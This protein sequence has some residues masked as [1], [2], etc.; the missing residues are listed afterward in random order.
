MEP[1]PVSRDPRLQNRNSRP[2]LPNRLSH[3]EAQQQASTVAQQPSAPNNQNDAPGD[4]FIRGI[5]DLVHRAVSA[6][7]N[8]NEKAKIKK[9][10]DET[11]DML[12]K[13]KSHSS[14]PSTVEF[15]QQNQEQE[16][17]AL[18][19]RD[20]DIKKY[21][22]E[23]Q[24]LVDDLKNKWAA[25]ANSNS[26]QSEE[27]VSRLQQDLKTANDKISNLHGEIAELSRRNDSNNSEMQ[28]LKA[29]V[30]I[31]AKS[32]TSCNDSLALLKHEM[33]DTSTRLKTME[34]R[35]IPPADGLTSRMQKAL[36]DFSLKYKSLEQK[37]TTLGDKI[38]TVSSSYQRISEIPNQVNRTLK[39]QEQKLSQI[40][41]DH[42]TQAKPSHDPALQLLENK[43]QELL[44]IQEI[45]SDFHLAEIEELKK[46]LSEL[47][48]L[49]QKCTETQ[50]FQERLAENLKETLSRTPR[51]PLDPKV[52]AIMAE[53]RKWHSQL[54]AMSMA[55]VS[56][57]SRYNNM[58]T[59]HIVQHMVGAMNEMYPSFER[60]CS[61]LTAYKRT[62]DDSLPFLQNR[63][64][65]L[66]SQGSKTRMIQDEL[67]LVK[68]KQSDL[69]RSIG[70]LSQQSQW[71]NQEDFQQMQTSLSS[72]V[73]K[74]NHTEDAFQQ[75]QTEDQ[76]ALHKISK[77]GELL[78]NRL[79]T[80]SDALERLDSDYNQAKSDAV[81][82]EDMHALQ[83][84]IAAVEEK[85]LEDVERLKD[86]FEHLKENNQPPPRPDLV[87]QDGLGMRIKRPFPDSDGERS[88]V[89]SNSPARSPD[90]TASPTVTSGDIKKKKK[91]KMRRLESR[92]QDPT[93]VQLDD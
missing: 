25:S 35:P 31:Q 70:E 38:G 93:P 80:L 29:M 48:A 73:E 68:A 71:V 50:Q 49:D 74:Q 2:S 57:E 13:A 20:E 34:E 8:T 75:K 10:R 79:S 36:D 67:N 51:E 14:F 18:T 69:T 44:D 16:R 86:R 83:N 62:V 85:T 26:S 21:E 28:S 63:M 59:E 27:T 77:E 24:R 22:A 23:Y 45:K 7:I 72:L 84:R 89:P 40:A 30:Q 82:D 55:L 43:F 91:K 1:Q 11:G 66:E 64:V 42:A 47:K 87:K 60:I 78:S 17:A 33:A 81:N 4:L 41:K 46:E 19:A 76:E 88:P 61:D 90:S 92:I 3:H 52:D 9:Q 32:S 15:Y 12:N 6:T 54:E 65:Q 5:P 56:L 37:M 39:D 53:V 58:T